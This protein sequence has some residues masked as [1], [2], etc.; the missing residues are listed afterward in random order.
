MYE[1]LVYPIPST[2]R[3]GNGLIDFTVLIVLGDM[4]ASVTRQ[5]FQ[6][7][8]L[9][10]CRRCIVIYPYIKNQN[11]ALFPIDLFQ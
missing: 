10:F 9:M 7:I 6:V 1:F 11:G 3:D 4:L 2:H 5:N 8:Y